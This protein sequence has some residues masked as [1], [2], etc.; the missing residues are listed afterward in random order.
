MVLGLELPDSSLAESKRLDALRQQYGFLPES[1]GFV[2]FRQ[3][4]RL[5]T[6]P[7]AAS[8]RAVFEALQLEVPRLEANCAEELDGMVALA[9]QMVFGM[10]TMDPTSLDSL[11]ILETEA[12]LTQDLKK[13]LAPVPGTAM[14]QTGLLNIALGLNVPEVV[15]L[16]TGAAEKVLA[17]PYQCAELAPINQS[18]AELK[19]ELAN[20]GLAMAGSVTG[21]HLA[22]QSLRMDATSEE[23]VKFSAALA[24]ASPTPVM[25]WGFAQA[26]LPPL[27]KVNMTM[28]GQVVALP[29]S[30]VPGPL[31]ILLK[32]V[33]HKDSIAFATQD[34]ADD[35]LLALSRVDAS[36]EPPLLHYGLSGGF[37][38]MLADTMAKASPSEG[39]EAAEAK[40][41]VDMVRRMGD[42]LEHMEISLGVGERGIEWRQRMRM[43]P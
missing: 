26:S 29:E 21:L 35:D 18:A 39:P 24:V 12:Q 25:L 36:A 38:A 11:A 8:E 13:V 40:R 31:P 34:V 32:A 20:P 2:D 30:L 33:M 23:P 19:Q 15:K 43:K 6:A 28:D 16:F 7:E 17:K 4:S 1:H 9:P 5:L 42:G 22:L 14:Q 27:T 3:L 41:A 37:A 10:V